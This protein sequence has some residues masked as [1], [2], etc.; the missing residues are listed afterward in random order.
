DERHDRQSLR[1]EQLAVVPTRYGVREQVDAPLSLP[2]RIGAG[3]IRIALCDR[4]A[5]AETDRQIGTRAE[6]D[7]VL[8]RELRRAERLARERVAARLIEDCRRSKAPQ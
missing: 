5:D 3:E 4:D 1:K 6:L 8:R 2:R 7:T